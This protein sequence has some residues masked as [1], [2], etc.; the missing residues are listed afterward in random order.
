M[1]VLS[2]LIV[3]VTHQCYSLLLVAAAA[4]IDDGEGGGYSYKGG[5]RGVINYEGK[6]IAMVCS[7]CYSNDYTCTK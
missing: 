3:F 1:N 2:D 6:R 4:Y 5:G 7:T